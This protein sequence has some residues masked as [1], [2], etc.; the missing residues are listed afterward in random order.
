[1][2]GSFI[3]LGEPPELLVTSSLLF[4]CFLGYLGQLALLFC[5][6]I[7]AATSTSSTI[8]PMVTNA[9]ERARQYNYVVTAHKPTAVNFSAVANFT[10]PNDTNLILM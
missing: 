5:L 10:H 6:F 9:L 3:C 8:S 4:T 7:M 1:M 2:S